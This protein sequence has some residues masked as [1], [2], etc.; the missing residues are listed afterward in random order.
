MLSRIEQDH[1]TL[2]LKFSIYSTCTFK[3]EIRRE[4]LRAQLSSYD[5]DIV[6]LQEHWLS[7]HELSLLNGID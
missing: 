1:K 6:L 3:N 5:A 7:K 4:A 2:H